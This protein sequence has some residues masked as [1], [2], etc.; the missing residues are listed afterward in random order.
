MLLIQGKKIPIVK[1]PSKG[2]F[3]IDSKLIVNCKTVPIFSTTFTSN[4]HKIPTPTTTDLMIQFIDLSDKGFLT[5]GFTKSSKTTADIEF[6]HVESELKAALKTPAM[7]RPASPGYSDNV[8]ST[9]R[10]RS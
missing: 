9:K 7:N 4:K 1:T 3:E 6:K 8:S 5:N 10:G 2:P